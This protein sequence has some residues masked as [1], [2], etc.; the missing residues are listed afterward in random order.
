MFAN[1]MCCGN[2]TPLVEKMIVI[3]FAIHYSVRSIKKLCAIYRS[4]R[5][6]SLRPHC[7]RANPLLGFD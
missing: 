3:I 7:Y 5:V 4:A 6:K 1:V 2:I